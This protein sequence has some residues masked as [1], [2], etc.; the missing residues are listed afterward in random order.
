MAT[1]L[2][3]SPNPAERRSSFKRNQV[4]IAAPQIE[5]TGQPSRL[6]QSA[7][8]RAQRGSIYQLNR[9]HGSLAATVLS[10]IR[11]KSRLAFTSPIVARFTLSIQKNRRLASCTPEKK[12]LSLAW[13]RMPSRK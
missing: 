6:D 11:K 13:S 8:L 1:K 2:R 9:T 3:M 5:E 7:A 10:R 4:L 12:A